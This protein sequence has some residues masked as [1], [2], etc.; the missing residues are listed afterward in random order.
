MQN[1][2]FVLDTNKRALTPVQPVVARKLLS[3]GKAAVFRRYPF[4]IILKEEVNEPIDADIRLKLDPGSKFTG[5]ALVRNNMVIWA[6]ELQHH[7]LKIKLDL[8]SRA[9]SRGS[10]RARKTRYRQ[11]RFLNRTKPK[12]WL[13]PSLMHRVLTVK[14]WV[15]RLSKYAPIGAI[16]QE[17]VRFDMQAMDNPEIEGAEYQ[18]GVLT[19]YEVREYLLEKWNRRCAYCG[20]ENTPLEIEHVHPKSRGGS[21]RIS[22]LTLA[23]HACNQKKGATPIEEFLKRKPEILK[24]IL[25]Q[26]KRPLAD[27]AAVNSTRWKLF[28]TLKSTEL[29]IEIGTGGRTKFN[30]RTLELPKAHWIDAACVGESGAS[31]KV[32]ANLKPLQIKSMGHGSRQM[33]RT[34]KYGFPNKHRTRQKTQFGFRTGDI[35]KAI[36]TTSKKA[37]TYVGRVSVRSAGR[38]GVGRLDGLHRRFFSLIQ[39]GDGYAYSI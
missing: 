9:A 35:A 6:A 18:Q 27:A 10:R 8:E 29:P 22:N 37:G 33:C 16:S 28:E 21:N 12:G 5:I 30:R 2:V 15:D 32:D 39:R 26:V 3:D 1:A 4:T 24:R 11:A 36:V 23:C 38:F 14:T 25:A 7:G 19:G 17:L 13:A 31:V 34:D 20:A